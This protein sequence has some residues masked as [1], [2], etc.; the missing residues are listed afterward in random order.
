MYVDNAFYATFDVRILFYL[1]K[2]LVESLK[3]D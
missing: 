2:A 1:F 3:E